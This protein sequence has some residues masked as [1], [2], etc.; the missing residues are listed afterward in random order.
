MAFLLVL[1]TTLAL[2]P[3]D[4]GHTYSVA[5][6][7]KIVLVLPSNGTTGYEWLLARRSD[8]SVVKLVSHSYVAPTT[9]RPGAA[10]T[11]VWRFE[12][13]GAGTARLQLA[14]A[15]PGQAKRAARRFAVTLRVR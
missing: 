6:P 7:T 11:E 1:L 4:N 13:V 10:G 8:R 12:A 14:Y 5:A 3:A 15:R 2:R 9:K